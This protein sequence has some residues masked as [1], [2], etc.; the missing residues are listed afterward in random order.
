[1]TERAPEAAAG[2]EPVRVAFRRS[3]GLAG[4][5]MTTD[6]DADQ[7]GS[8]H[9]AVVQDLLSDE[10]P[11]AAPTASGA[12]DRFAYELTVAGGDRSRTYRWGEAEVPE[13]VKPLVAELTARAEPTRPG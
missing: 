9:A 4:L 8:S 12:P 3:G 7:L 13:Q 5:T 2:A 10:P 1:V 6:L 11:P